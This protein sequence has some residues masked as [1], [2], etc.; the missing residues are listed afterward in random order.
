MFRQTKTRWNNMMDRFHSPSFRISRKGKWY[1][2]AP[3]VI[4]LT[5]LIIVLTINFNLGIDFTGGQ[6]IEV[7]GDD[8]AEHRQTIQNFMGNVDANIGRFEVRAA[9]TNQAGVTLIEVFFQNG[10]VPDSEITALAT[11][12]AQGIQEHLG[13]A[14]ITAHNMQGVSASATGEHIVTTVIAVGV[15]LIAILVYMLFRFKFTSGVAALVGL[16]HDVLVMLAVTAIFRVP[17]N[18]AFVAALITV[19]A[20]SINNTLILFD[21]IRHLEKHNT[22]KESPEMITDRAVKETFT[23]TMLTMV[24][25][26][27][28]IAILLIAGV[29]LIREFAAPILFGLVAGTFSTVFVATSLYVRFETYRTRMVKSKKQVE[30]KQP[31]VVE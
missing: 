31:V 13:V 3:A 1:A 29:P 16:V 19:V 18:A 25:T 10:S 21:R 8:V 23:R 6:L 28:P 24:T 26:L 11:S 15:A 5:G 12:I 4:I 7:R 22:L 2:I 17:V 30:I 27:V 9:R 14:G 20:Y